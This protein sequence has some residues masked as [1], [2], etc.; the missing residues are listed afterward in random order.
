MKTFLKII[1]C[2]ASLSMS[3]TSLQIPVY[4]EDGGKSDDIVILY[5]NDVH[6]GIDDNIGYDGLALNKRE[7]QQEYENVLLVDAGDAI[8]G[9]PIGSISQ[10]A[11]ITRIMNA[12]GYDAATIGNHEFDYGVTE[13]MVRAEE[14][15]CGYI[16]ANLYNTETGE[17]LFEP[18]KILDAGDKRIAFVGAVTPETP[19]GSTPIY[20]QNDK[21]EYIYSFGESGDLYELLQNAVDSAL[22]EGADYVILLA[23]L[24]E[25]D[26]TEGWSAQEVVQ[27]LTGVDAVIDGH[28]HDVTSS[29]IVKSKDGKDVT[30]TQTGTKLANIGKMTI[31]ADGT[32]STELIDEVPAPEDYSGISEDSWLEP[33]GRE[34]RFA[35]E[36][37]NMEM[38]KI[39]SEYSVMLE[40]VIGHSDFDLL[41]K[42]PETGLRIVRSRETNLGDFCADAYRYVLGADVGIANGGGV[43]TDIL[44]GDITYNDVLTVFPFGN[45]PA[46]AEVTGQQILDVLESGAKNYPGE[47]GSFIQVSGIEYTIDESIESSVRLD[48]HGEFLG[49]FGEYRV[50]N[51]LINGEPLD[52]EK[53]YTLAAHNYYLENGGDG[54]IFSGKCKILKENMMT[55]AELL[56]VYIRDNLGG[57]IPEKYSEP[58]GEGRIK[59]INSASENAGAYN[60]QLEAAADTQECYVGD[61]FIVTIRLENTGTNAL[62][63]AVVYFEDNA[64][65]SAD[66]LEAGK[67]TEFQIKLK[68]WEED[69]ASGGSINISAIADEISEPVKTVCIVNVLPLDQESTE[70]NPSTGTDNTAL[71]TLCIVSLVIAGLSEKAKNRISR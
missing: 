67:A 61:E 48:E 8:Q 19:F 58:Y 43:R 40:E 62:T 64:V 66:T 20:F 69:I 52:T 13:L 17:L 24:G 71:P 42:D 70:S 31:T 47:N 27:Q 14:L 45:M 16:C 56:A 51:V 4:A 18:Y 46:L 23:H 6:C 35:D 49:V 38:L 1:V 57:V 53:I 54:Y 28:S 7:M 65:Y 32:I 25:T 12:V 3:L 44:A 15:N 36:A 30:I 26:V 2:A 50:K 68:A 63:N 21:G 9:A 37:V 55:D 41:A 34:G 33:D 59:T 11:Y 10:G 60:L 39:E 29:L 22:N 5:T